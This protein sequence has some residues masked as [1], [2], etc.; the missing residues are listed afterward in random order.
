MAICCD[1]EMMDSKVVL[2]RHNTL[3]NSIKRSSP[4]SVAEAA[5]YVHNFKKVKIRKDLED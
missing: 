1:K 5:N 4:E 2:S 3:I